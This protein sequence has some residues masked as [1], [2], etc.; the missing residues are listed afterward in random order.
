MLKTPAWILERAKGF[1][2]S[3]QNAQ[4]AQSQNDLQSAN[5]DYTQIRAQ[6]LGELGPELAQVVAVW[7]KLSP[8]LKAA[9][10]AIVN[11]LNEAGPAAGLEASASKAHP[12]SNFPV[13]PP[14]STGNQQETAEK[15]EGRQ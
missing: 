11:S 10:L 12:Q 4:A 1:E 15:N 9:I 13:V 6:I 8:P 2:P 5:S 7:S 14:S 3:S